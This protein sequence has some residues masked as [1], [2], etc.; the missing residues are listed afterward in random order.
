MFLFFCGI[1]F[2]YLLFLNVFR[3]QYPYRI[4]E[5]RYIELSPL[6]EFMRTFPAKPTNRTWSEP[7][8]QP[9]AKL[10]FFFFAQLV[11][12]KKLHTLDGR[13]PAPVDMENINPMFHRVSCVTGGAGF[14]PSTVVITLPKT[15]SSPLKIGLFNRKFHLPTIHFAGAMLVSGRVGSI[16]NHSEFRWLVEFL[17]EWQVINNACLRLFQ[18]NFGTHP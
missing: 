4:S 2:E 8:R 5:D 7:A 16:G 12:Q 15:N 11:S 13:N 1:F 9:N 14:L 17:G 6:F 3:I 18:H 10:R